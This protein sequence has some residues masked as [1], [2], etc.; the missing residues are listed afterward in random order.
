MRKPLIAIVIA[1][2]ALTLSSCHK[3]CSCTKY[4][5][6]I[7]KY[8]NEQVEAHGTSCSGMIYMY[9]TRYYSLCEW[10]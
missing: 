2:F 10:E 8:S 7:D 4:D 6:Q 3:T 1:A 9:N 5:G